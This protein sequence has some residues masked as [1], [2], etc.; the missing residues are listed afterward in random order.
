MYLSHHR[1]FLQVLSPNTSRRPSHGTS[2]CW[3]PVQSSCALLWHPRRHRIGQRS[4]IHLPSLESLLTPRCDR[5]PLLWLPS[6]V[7]WADR[8]QDPGSRTFPEN[9][10]PWPPELL[11]PVSWLGRVCPEFPASKLNWT[12]S[13]P[14]RTRFPASPVSMVRGTIRC[15]RGRSLVPRESGTQHIISCSRQCADK[16]W[17][18]TSDDLPVPRTNLGKGSGCPHRT[19]SCACQAGSSVPD[20]LALSPF[21]NG[22]TPVT[23][24]LQLPPHY[25]IHP[26]FHVS[27]LKPF[28]PSVSP[29]PGQTEEQPLPLIQDW[30]LITLTCTSSP[31]SS[32][33]V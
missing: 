33:P 17:Q 23:Y 29:E 9:L 22:S 18:R 11:E 3:T 13:L 7:E 16:G 26:T 21:W 25:R 19:S 30:I 28:S 4:T 6:A 10:L 32:N 12:H 8:A 2:D 5:E 27:L 24:K 31:L 14:V 15:P 20:S 1:P